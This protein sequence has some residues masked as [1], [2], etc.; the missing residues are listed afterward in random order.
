MN[1][2]ERFM[3][4]KLPSKNAFY[5]KL[6]M[7]VPVI[8]IINLHSNQTPNLKADVLLLAHVLKTFRDTYQAE[9]GNFESGGAN[10]YS[11]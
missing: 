3:K 6:S 9:W 2:W 10:I 11:I 4:I 1:S 7:K 8:K 5:R